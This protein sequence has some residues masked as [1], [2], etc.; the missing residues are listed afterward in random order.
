M[1]SPRNGI[2]E[3]IKPIILVVQSNKNM[4]PSIIKKTPDIIEMILRCLFIRF[5]RFEKKPIKMLARI[6]G[7]PSPT[8]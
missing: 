5:S 4:I 7:N 6:K 1:S 2:L 8:E 3:V